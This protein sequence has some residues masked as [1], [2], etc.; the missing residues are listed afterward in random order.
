MISNDRNSFK[1][2]DFEKLTDIEIALYFLRILDDHDQLRQY[3]SPVDGR[4]A[5][6]TM[7]DNAIETMSNPYAIRLL[8]D[9]MTEH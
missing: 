3:Q 8:V 9:R 5:I 4:I 1:P 7:V 6:F 2:F